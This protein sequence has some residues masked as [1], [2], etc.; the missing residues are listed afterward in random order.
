MSRA[1]GF[2][3]A[4]AT[5][6]DGLVAL[7]RRRR[8]LLASLVESPETVI[9]IHVLTRGDCNVY[10]SGDRPSKAVAVLQAR[11]WASE[12]TGFGSDADVLW[13]ALAQVKGWDCVLVDKDVAPPLGGIISRRL[14]TPVRLLDDIYHVPGGEV[15]PFE[16]VSVRRLALDDL[17]LLE[18]LPTE[19]QPIGFW[20]DLQTSLTE[21]LIAG[22]IVE[23][24]V[25]ATSFVAALGR[26]YADLGVY[27][28]QDHRRRGL[29]TAAASIVA[30]TAQNDGLIP[31]W[32]CGSHNLAS[33][34][35]A[36]KLGFVEVSR[37]A[38]V[39][40]EKQAPRDVRNRT[41]PARNEGVVQ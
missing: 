32:S 16:D 7:E 20:G 36:R 21:G 34:K 25:V 3:V 13:Q 6:H 14:D 22:A 18:G 23:G 24:K 12:P 26:R 27:V 30:R 15:A 41:Y 17:T 1:A 29:A 39:V 5:G 38:Y 11:G 31:V 9:S 8:L 19:A 10:M 40:I 4:G 28:L 2:E 37:R 33:L 35:L